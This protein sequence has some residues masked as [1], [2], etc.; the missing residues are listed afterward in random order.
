MYIYKCVKCNGVEWSWWDTHTLNI[1]QGS[2]IILKEKFGK[3]QWEII[4]NIEP[5]TIRI[6]EVLLENLKRC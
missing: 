1:L 3:E 4:G 5:T 6:G 2:K